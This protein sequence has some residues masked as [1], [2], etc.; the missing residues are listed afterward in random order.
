MG[1]G[2]QKVEVTRWCKGLQEYWE[3]SQV[4][5][6]KCR[7]AE[8]RQDVRNRS[9]DALVAMGLLLRKLTAKRDKF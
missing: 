8:S 5:W 1:W 3:N 2:C 6:A 4:R 9:E 7:G